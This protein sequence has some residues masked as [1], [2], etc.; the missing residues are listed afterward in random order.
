TAAPLRACPARPPARLSFAPPPVPETLGVEA[1]ACAVRWRPGALAQS[2]AAG[3]PPPRYIRVTHARPHGR[4]PRCCAAAP[5]P[6]PRPPPS[7]PARAPAA[8]PPAR[9]PGALPPPA[10]AA[11]ATRCSGRA[12]EAAPILIPIPVSR[13]GSRS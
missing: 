8:R 5:P 6:L 13:S 4:C 12:G 11:P 9:A 3:R 7:F 10:R 2:P 1:G